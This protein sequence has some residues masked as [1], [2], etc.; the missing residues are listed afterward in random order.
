MQ[1]DRMNDADQE[2]EGKAAT[3]AGAA[4]AAMS[5]LKVPQAAPQ[6]TA[7]EPRAGCGVQPQSRL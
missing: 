7:A 2:A 6:R 4:A 3:A 5:E 1:T